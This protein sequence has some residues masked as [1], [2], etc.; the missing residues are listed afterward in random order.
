MKQ[1]EEI[2]F[3]GGDWSKHLPTPES[4]FK[5]RRINLLHAN[6]YL[7]IV[8]PILNYVSRFLEKSFHNPT[9]TIGVPNSLLLPFLLDWENSHWS[10]KANPLRMDHDKCLTI[11]QRMGTA[12]LLQKP[13]RI[14][15]ALSHSAQK[16]II[17][18]INPQH[19]S[20]QNKFNSGYHYIYVR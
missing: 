9:V 10:A 16:I 11:F 3:N 18:W 6:D 5:V 17:E 20:P 12:L 13:L 14:R 19:F 8:L 1:T 2:E 15:T 4:I 7:G